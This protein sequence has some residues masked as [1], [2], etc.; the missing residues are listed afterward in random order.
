MIESSGTRKELQSQ[1]PYQRRIADLNMTPN[2]SSKTSDGEKPQGRSRIQLEYE[3]AQ[4]EEVIQW[5]DKECE[6]E[7]ER[8]GL[9]VLVQLLER[10]C[11]RLAG[12]NQGKE[13]H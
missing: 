12:Y 4:L 10:K 1:R 9:H 3:I 11:A 5:M 13:N 8:R 7:E 2:R 6:N